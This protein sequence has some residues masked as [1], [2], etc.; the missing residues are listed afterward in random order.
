MKVLRVLSRRN[1]HTS[2]DWDLTA[3]LR[4]LFP[5]LTM[6]VVLLLLRLHT[7]HPYPAS[8]QLHFASQRPMSI[9]P[10]CRWKG[11]GFIFSSQRCEPLWIHRALTND[12][13]SILLRLQRKEAR[14]LSSPLAITVIFKLSSVTY[15]TDY[16]TIGTKIFSWLQIYWR[17]WKSRRL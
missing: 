13:N 4:N 6:P 1:F 17:L 15:V 8:I 3:S 14:E 5:W 9:A 7:S 16:C 11:A 12:S 10:A 2:E